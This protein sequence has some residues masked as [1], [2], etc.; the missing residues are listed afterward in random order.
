MFLDFPFYSS[1]CVYNLH[2]V[3][4]SG[5]TQWGTMCPLYLHKIGE[6]FRTIWDP[7]YHK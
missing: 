3:Q 5:A 1:V 2:K 6:K 7:I 4:I